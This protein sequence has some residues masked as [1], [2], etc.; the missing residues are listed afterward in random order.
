MQHEL[1]T[2][3]GEEG[4]VA[5]EERF[6]FPAEESE[7]H[8]PFYYS[9]ETGPAHVI[10]LG[11]YVDYSSDSD[12]ADWLIKDLAKVDRSRTPWLVVGMHVSPFSPEI[13]ILLEV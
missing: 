13:L 5:Y 1:E 2:L 9:Y 6:Y 12:Q 3:D 10:M 7:S 8:S 4:F 11:C